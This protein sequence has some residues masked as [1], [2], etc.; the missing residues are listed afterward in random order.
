MAGGLKVPAAGAGGPEHPSGATPDAAPESAGGTQSIERAVALL[1]LVGRAGAEGARLADLVASSGLSKPTV[2]R[3]LLALV[4]AGLVDQDEASRRYHVGPEAYVLGTLAAPRF[5]IHALALDGL[6]RI[7]RQSGDCAFLSVPRGAFSVCLHR[8]EGTWPIRTHVLQAGDRHPLGIGAGG[9]AI[10]AA[11]PEA[12]AARILEA[13]AAALAAYPGYS[14]DLLRGAMGDTRARG[15]A[16]NPGLYVAGSWG[17][18]VPVR[19]ADGRPLGALSLAA[20]ESRLGA[21][22]QKELV[23]LLQREAAALEAKLGGSE[24]G[25]P[26][27][28]ARSMARP[29]P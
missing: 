4:R 20:I 25:P 13:N 22:R 1:M 15:Y 17:I 21:E 9:L 14:P 27:R 5:G 19:G 18:G 8:E 29:A 7:A 12:E 2:R 28:P 16:L 11:L 24:R 6:S 23:P 10:L 3:V 26:Q